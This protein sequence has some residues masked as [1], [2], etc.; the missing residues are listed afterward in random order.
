M[1]VP[2]KKN[3]RDELPTLA[4][5]KNLEASL[6]HFEQ[7]YFKE[8]EENRELKK[9]FDAKARHMLFAFAV[10]SFV[11][12]IL[13]GIKNP[14]FMQDV[15]DFLKWLKNAVISLFWMGVAGGD[16]VAEIFEKIPL[17]PVAFLLEIVGY[18]VCV[19]GVFATLIA[20]TVLLVIWIQY[21]CTDV[22]LP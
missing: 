19:V 12:T 21:S 18:L 10:Y 3:T 14:M 5:Y 6:K 7:R 4:D 17:E 16:F 22:L 2:R 8:A 15:M 13:A 11:V 20:L 9:T 1:R